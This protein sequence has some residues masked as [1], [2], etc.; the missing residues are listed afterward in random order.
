MKRYDPDFTREGW[1][2][3]VYMEETPQ[4]DYVLYSDHRKAV[5][6]SNK[7]FSELQGMYQETLGRI[8]EL[9]AAVD[10]L[11]GALEE[12]VFAANNPYGG[13]IYK[14]DIDKVKAAIDKYRERSDE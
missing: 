9:E 3:E 11:V 5:E 1:F 10:E 14:E 2:V 4:G 6:Q 12:I 7:D 13:G 8:A